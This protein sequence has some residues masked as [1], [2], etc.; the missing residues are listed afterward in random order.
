MLKNPA[1]VAEY[2]SKSQG[3][4]TVEHWVC[5]QVVKAECKTKT[6]NKHRQIRHAFMISGGRL[7]PGRSVTGVI[8][9]VV[10]PLRSCTEEDGK[11]REFMIN[12]TV[13]N[14]L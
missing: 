12:P 5:V 4:W 13:K 7:M 8:S 3:K 9:G 6:S 1:G 11:G 2:Q 14:C 10:V